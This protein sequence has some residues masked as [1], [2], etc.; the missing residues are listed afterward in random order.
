MEAGHP[1][2][3]DGAR[4]GAL[5]IDG[6]RA[7]YK[8]ATRPHPAWRYRLLG[9]FAE[10]LDIPLARPVRK[11]GGALGL[12]IERRRIVEL[13]NAGV[14]V[15]RILAKGDDWH[16][17]SD[18]GPSLRTLL[19]K[20]DSSGQ[21]RLALRT[22]E[23]LQAVHEKRQYLSQAFDRNICIG[24]RVAFIDF[25]DDPGEVYSLSEAQ[26]RDWLLLLSSMAAH[27]ERDM[28]ALREI[29]ACATERLP[30][31]RRAPLLITLE[32]ARGFL[33]YIPGAARA[34]ETR[35]LLALADA[36][37]DH[38]ARQFAQTPPAPS[39]TRAISTHAGIDRPSSDQSTLAHSPE[40]VN[41]ISSV[42]PSEKTS[43]M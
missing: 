1:A 23:A 30:E 13:A 20:A 10:R 7:W 22:V 37:L 15:P 43:S 11:P 39:T 16:V 21:R 2:P 27:F 34:R 12:Q 17:L 14:A 40:P 6:D 3:L 42:S 29:S 36:V 32:R 9:A 19:K 31:D 4:V 8:R 26:A 38:R 33:R 5:T 24:T 18:C 28:P 25:E 35:R 41:T